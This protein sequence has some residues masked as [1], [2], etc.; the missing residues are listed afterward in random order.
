MEYASATVAARQEK[1]LKRAEEWGLKAL[2]SP[3]CNPSSDA[4]SPYFLA[5]EVYREQKNYTKMA[6]MLTIAE[7]RNPDQLI[8]DGYIY[9]DKNIENIRDAVWAIRDN[10]W[11]I[12]YN[13]AVN[14][15]SEGNLSQALEQ[16]KVAEIIFPIKTENY[17]TPAI[18]YFESNDKDMAIK[19]IDRGL[20]MDHNDAMLLQF[21]ADI[22]VQ[23]NELKSAKEL[24]LKAIASSEDPGPIKIKLLNIY[25]ELG[26]NEM[27]IDFSDELL[28]QYPDD[29]D[30]YY[31]VG[32]V[33]Q[34]LASGIYDSNLNQFNTMDLTP[35]DLL[36]LYK[37]Y[38]QV[39]EYAYNARDSFLQASDLEMEENNSTLKAAQEMKKMMKN[40]DDIF[41]PSIKKRARSADIELE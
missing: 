19:T 15:Y 26:E 29:S 38:K 2:K 10:D 23:N 12:V 40:V 18:W 14:S 24:Y 37:S 17:S 32:V 39:R 30:I 33:Y 1:N 7:Q 20:Q 27:A 5:K 41:I 34:R 11:K 9:G 25:I 28:Y 13:N 31:N 6:E 22:F 16:I 35:E 3:A 8:E 4:L 21:K 36:N